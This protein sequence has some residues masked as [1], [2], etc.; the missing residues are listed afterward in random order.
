MIHITQYNSNFRTMS[1]K[2][3]SHMM[4]QYFNMFI[5]SMEDVVKM[6]EIVDS[7]YSNVYPNI[8][9]NFIFNFDKITSL[10][11][12]HAKDINLV[13][14]YIHKIFGDCFEQYIDVVGVFNTDDVEELQCFVF[15]CLVG[16]T[17]NRTLIYMCE[18]NR[19]EE[20]R[21]IMDTII[22]KTHTLNNHIQDLM[23]KYPA[24]K[25][26]LHMFKQQNNEQ[27]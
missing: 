27:I 15:H 1:I 21:D 9:H 18:S 22:Q 19:N 25:N 11:I 26:H 23:D 20:F 13:I 17:I 3:T 14:A 6:Q 5:N 24:H 4:I 12:L 7:F 2:Q 16:Q 8:A 10:L